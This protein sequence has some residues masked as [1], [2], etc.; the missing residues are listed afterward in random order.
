MRNIYLFLFCTDIVICSSVCRKWRLCIKI[1]IDWQ[2]YCL[3]VGMP[4]PLFSFSDWVEYSAQIVFMRG[5]WLNYNILCTPHGSIES[6][7]QRSLPA[8]ITLELTDLVVGFGSLPLDYV[9]SLFL[10][11]QEGSFALGDITMIRNGSPI[12]QDRCKNGITGVCAVSIGYVAPN[13]SDGHTPAIDYDVHE[14][15]MSFRVNE[16]REVSFVR[17]T[18]VCH[19]LWSDH[20]SAAGF[21][22]EQGD[23]LHT[24]KWS[25]YGF[26]EIYIEVYESYAL[27]IL[28]CTKQISKG[29]IQPCP[30]CCNWPCFT[31]CSMKWFGFAEEAEEFPP[32]FCSDCALRLGTFVDLGPTH[33]PYADPGSWNPLPPTLF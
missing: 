10:I 32:M 28:S 27:M 21:I 9:A 16:N 20:R 14:I 25:S 31:P 33:N 13:G 30:G 6:C 12:F 1:E 17:Y 11:W 29:A 7:L 18:V 8:W 15:I 19:D 3:H 24:H 23:A 5:C 4:L 26:P 22:A 2:D